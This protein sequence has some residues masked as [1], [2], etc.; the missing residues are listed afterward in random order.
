MG[1]DKLLDRL[2]QLS[3]EEMASLVSAAVPAETRAHLPPERAP[4]AERAVALFTLAQESPAIAEQLDRR[5]ADPIAEWLSWGARK[6]GSVR[7]VGFQDRYKIRLSLE[8][9]FVSLSV[10]PRGR[11]E[12]PEEARAGDRAGLH[13]R[14]LEPRRTTLAEALALA[15]ATPNTAGVVL[16]GDPGAGKTTLLHHLFTRVAVGSS[17][18]VGLADGLCPVY[19]R[20]SSVTPEDRRRFGLK[21]VLL[22]QAAQDGYAGAGRRVV[23]ERRPVLFLLDGL[24]EVR[25]KATRAAVCEWLGEEVAHWPGSRFVVTCRFTA[26]RYEARLDT[27]FVRVDVEWLDEPRVREFVHRWYHAVER[28]LSTADRPAE[29]AAEQAEALLR[30]VLDRERQ[31]NIRLREMTENPLLLSTLCLVHHSDVRLPDKRGELYDRCISLLLET[32]PAHAGRPGLPDKQARLVLEPLAY[33]MHARTA[34]ELPAGEAEALLAGPIRRVP[35]L[36]LS[37]SELLQIACEQ[38]GVLASR[39]YGTFEFFHLSFQEYLCAAHM[40]EAGLAAELARRADDPW[41]HEVVLLA[42][43]MRGMFT[44]LVRGLIANGSLAAQTELVRAC[45]DETIEIDE[46]PFVDVL[47]GALER[48]AEPKTGVWAAL[49]RWI[50]RPLPDVAPVAVAVLVIAHGRELPGVMERAARLVSHPNA[51]VA[52]AARALVGGPAVEQVTEQVPAGGVWREPVTGMSFLWVPPGTFL[53]GSSKEHGTA[54]FDPKAYDNETPAHEVEL[55]QG[56]W[57][58]EHPVT[59]AAYGVFL[60]ETKHD[61]PPYWQNRRFNA[62]EQPVITVSFED[63]LAFCE[64]LTERLKL[65]E[66]WFIDLPTEA[67]WE[68]AARGPDGRRYPWGNEEPTAERACF[69]AHGD[70]PLPVGGRPAGKGPYGCQDMAGNVWEWCLDAWH[71][72][73]GDKVTGL[74]NPCHRGDRGARR[75]IRGGSWDSSAGNLRCAVR[76]GLRPGYRDGVIGFRVVCRVSRQLWLDES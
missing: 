11:G 61:E 41:W 33:A 52:A 69:G 42:M 65:Q 36:R 23:D 26:F 12:T 75:I 49:S 5:L 4:S 44:A 51:R 34:R 30:V 55:T 56:I 63:A 66:G 57:M 9:V 21:E 60:A 1:D 10:Q 38:C 32:W 6:Y 18:E 39:S 70:A 76:S 48:M 47:D 53:M 46:A 20:C 54:G 31:R 43:S 40:K 22:R 72:S 24:D 58:C 3:A 8:D 50:H 13:A 45:L 28:G 15:D 27:Q 35:G 17:A 16:L 59:N 62:P 64:W 7:V 37:P 68:H 2:K 71:G 74:V 73:D 67:E 25:D 14:A 19:I 29:C